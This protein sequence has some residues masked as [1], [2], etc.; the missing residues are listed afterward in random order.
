LSEKEKR[1]DPES[2]PPET[3]IFNGTGV[4]YS[5]HL[6]VLSRMDL[7]HENAFEALYFISG[8]STA[9]CVATALEK[10]FCLWGRQEF[11]NWNALVKKS[12]G[13]H[14]FGGLWKLLRIRLGIL[15]PVFS[16]E[17]YR[18]VYEDA[19]T[20]DFFKIRLGDLA[21]NVIVPL[22]D[23]DSGDIVLATPNSEFADCPLY[24]VSFAST[25]IPKVYPNIRINGR[26]YGD[27]VYARGFIP[28]VKS[29]E[30]SSKRFKNYNLFKSAVLA[31]GEYICLSKASNPKREL[32][33]DLIKFLCGFHIQSYPD[34]IARSAFWD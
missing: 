1:L 15:L 21:G 31:N 24:K 28:W 20:P 5:W 9:L 8:A 30:A 11:L 2:S 25:A 4:N 32:Q 7:T 33:V 22:H 13:N 3:I 23:L 26:V 29:V 16:E 14:L 19:T 17:L 12:Y 10:G 18:K 27:P 6:P 34:N